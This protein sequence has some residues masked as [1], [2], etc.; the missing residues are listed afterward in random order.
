MT[1]CDLMENQLTISNVIELIPVSIT[2]FQEQ[3][4][5]ASIVAALKER[6]STYGDKV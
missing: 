1:D 5:D 6:L 3:A 2:R 4:L